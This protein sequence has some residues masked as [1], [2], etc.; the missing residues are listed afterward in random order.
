MESNN[1]LLVMNKIYS[2]YGEV[3]VLKGVSVDI[4]DKSITCIIG[5]NGAGKSTLLKTI[6]GIVPV[7]TGTIL[8]NGKNITNLNPMTIL[9]MGISFVPQGRCNFPNM[10]VQENLEMGGFTIKRGTIEREIDDV[11]AKFPILCQKRKDLAGNLSGGQQQI[12]EM[13]MSLILKPKI[14]LIDEPTLG[15]APNLVNDVFET[16]IN[17]NDQGTTV[18]IVEQNAKKVLEISDFAFVLDLGKN[19]MHG[20]AK[21]ISE[22]PK[23]KLHYLGL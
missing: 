6:F 13:A 8:C 5:P 4:F 17:V 12:L 21:E 16:I 19:W 14:L 11:F 7:E 3:K 18:L 22:N 20:T 10:T 1:P 9:E 23:V 2:G 15:L